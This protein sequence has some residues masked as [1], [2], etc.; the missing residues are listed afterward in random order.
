M[1][2]AA[3]ENGITASG[4]P[5][6]SSVSS[7]SDAGD[8]GDDELNSA[9]HASN[10]ENKLE[11]S[12]EE[13]LGS[14][15]TVYN[16]DQGDFDI[17][18]VHGLYG[19]NQTTWETHDP[20]TRESLKGLLNL[21]DHFNCRQ[22]NYSYT[23]DESVPSRDEIFSEAF[24]LLR[25]IMEARRALR[26]GALRPIVFI[27]H[28][29]GGAIVKRIFFG[30]PHRSRSFQELTDALARLVFSSPEKVSSWSKGVV[31]THQLAKT[32]VECNN[33]F[34]ESKMLLHASILNI[35]SEKPKVNEQIFDKY[36]ATINLK[37]QELWGILV[38]NIQWFQ[39]NYL[40]TG[41]G[42][43][44]PSLD[45]FASCAPPLYPLTKAG[46]TEPAWLTRHPAFAEWEQSAVHSILLVRGPRDESDRLAESVFAST[47]PLRC[48]WAVYFS[49]DRYDARRNTVKA[50]LL[51]CIAQ[52]ARAGQAS[53]RDA[54]MLRE[55]AI[56]GASTADVFDA[57]R[58]M[59]MGGAQGGRTLA[60]LSNVGE[61][62]DMV[63]S[64]WSQ[65][66]RLF[67]TTEAVA[68]KFVVFARPDD[69]LDAGFKEWPAISGDAFP[70]GSDHDVDREVR[71]AVP[72]LLDADYTAAAERTLCKAIADRCGR[73][74]GLARFMT[75]QLRRMS[76]NP[77]AITASV[78]KLVEDTLDSITCEG[79]Q[80]LVAIT[81]SWVLCAFRPPSLAELAAATGASCDLARVLDEL[82]PGMLDTSGSNVRLS[83]A[84]VR[85]F[86]QTATGSWY[87]VES[88][89][90]STI[91]RTCL[92]HLTSTTN[93]RLSALCDPH[94]GVWATPICKPQNDLTAYAAEYWHEHYKLAADRDS[95]GR[96]VQDFLQNSTQVS[97][98][99]RARWA[100]ANPITRTPD[101][102]LS[103]LALI[104]SV[105]LEEVFDDVFDQLQGDEIAVRSA[106][107]EA[108]R[109]GHGNLALRILASVSS[110]AQLDASTANAALLAA[111][112]HGEHEDFQLALVE[113]VSDHLGPDFIWPPQLLLRAAHLGH[114][115][116]VQALIQRGA[117]VDV[118]DKLPAK[119]GPLHAAVVAGRMQ[120]AMVLL[121]A[122][123]SIASVRDA[124]G[125]SP[126]WLAVV[127][128]HADVAT[129]L[130]DRGGVDQ[131]AETEV[132]VE[133]CRL[134][135]HAA[136]RSL[137]AAR[138]AGS[139][140][141]ALLAA[142]ERGFVECARALVDYGVDVNGQEEDETALYKAVVGGHGRMCRFLLQNGADP[143]CSGQRGPAIVVAV[144]NN[145]LDIVE[146]LVQHE[147]E[148]D[149]RDNEHSPTA[150]MAAL[151]KNV[152]M[153]WY[154]LQNGADVDATMDSD[155]V[156][157]KAAGGSD[158]DILR[159]VVDAGAALNVTS[160]DGWTPLH[161]A[162]ERA[163]HT[164]LLLRA[165]ADIDK[166]N[167][168]NGKSPLYLAAEVNKPDV[169]D[170]LLEFKPTLDL[171]CP[172]ASSPSSTALIAA[173]K[174]GCLEVVKKL[175]AA[176]ASP[177]VQTDS[178]ASVV[179]FAVDQGADMLATLL[180]SEPN[181]DLTDRSGDTPLNDF[182]EYDEPSL[183]IVRLLV[184]AGCDVNK[185]NQHGATPLHKA[186]AKENLDVARFLLK[187]SRADI[188]LAPGSWGAP[189]HT[190]CYL[191]TA[192][193]N[194][195]SLLLD[196]G[197]DTN[198]V[199]SH[200]GTPA[201]FLC[202][203]VH[204]H[205]Y[206]RETEDDIEAVLRLLQDK[207][208]KKL[209][210]NLAGGVLGTPLVSACLTAPTTRMVDMLLAAGADVDVAEPETGRLPVHHAAQRSVDFFETLA[211]AGANLSARDSAGCSV[212]SYASQSASLELVRRVLQWTE[213][214]GMQL[215]H[216]A[217]VDGWT[218]LHHA[219]RG[220]FTQGYAVRM[221]LMAGE[222]ENDED[223]Q[224]RSAGPLRKGQGEVIKFLVQKGAD[225]RACVRGPDGKRWSPLKLARYHGADEEVQILLTPSDGKEWVDAEHEV[226]E[227]TP[228]PNNCN[229]CEFRVFGWLYKC[230]VCDDFDYCFKCYA[231]KDSSPHRD[232]E[233]EQIG[234]EFEEE[235]E[236]ESESEED[237]R[238]YDDSRSDSSFSSNSD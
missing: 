213:K 71:S 38:N 75:G 21:G 85:A 36:M 88:T 172:T 138:N 70:T 191:P 11:R 4:S 206:S 51:S 234:P 165:G 115:A 73:D 27:S 166:L 114:T 151:E 167:V 68:W 224:K 124:N 1:S 208:S 56:S 127:N 120:V 40:R 196:A 126:L 136:A 111:A 104:A 181:L 93:E 92:N 141:M 60:V 218:P 169:V 128:G 231:R 226:K 54:G 84:E 160:R 123:A 9:V 8:S 7:E 45:V 133:A 235:E 164:R 52:W 67:T 223:V 89:A 31:Q 6:D 20:D 49:F 90:H 211:V 28:D 112:S 233:W 105:G 98:W 140:Q 200:N 209:D 148:V 182:L 236:S 194:A 3:E 131:E 53:P 16:E 103:P 184:G 42:K 102:Q 12:G 101:R 66:A 175:L 30:Y 144:E 217:D 192:P 188:G 108:C 238:D 152:E 173:V 107:I 163:G 2:N 47:G 176:G 129:V 29:I 17:V 230:K 14:Q 201:C 32:I 150:L 229:G 113:H 55:R 65:M 143:N 214:A 174:N 58:R 80:E 212:L 225:L 77:E 155:P 99:G 22:L 177:D 25:Y 116:V 204:K 74:V 118:A 87:A 205:G 26:P 61:C 187:C 189:L 34:V 237:A 159:A 24:G 178:G 158:I 183:S 100:V 207:S 46:Y 59:R 190:A 39:K 135:M 227:G 79:K 81:L 117:S 37:D 170:A 132:I 154:L 121:D 72:Q 5:D 50:F 195:V 197:A 18:T 232:H 48:D 215:L 13:E 156:I 125:L 153:V 186:V 86:L 161:G 10:I 145:R 146:L 109:N 216:E 162:F 130:L 220:Y 110:S 96:C 203:R 82:L 106:L 210:L 179:H 157:F 139:L 149:A 76:M 95:L 41:D 202:M 219:A 62:D 78:A 222:D 35:F 19:D 15:S 97:R 147:A 168:G 23:P 134:G 33:G 185:F 221:A 171:R 57:W 198:Q 91:T 142:A 94:L 199:S 193:T 228:T 44:D 137:L 69:N 122:D 43:P 119:Q 63:P 83:H 180:E 64:F